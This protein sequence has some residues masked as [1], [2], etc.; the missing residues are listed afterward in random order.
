M[1]ESFGS[2]ES[3]DEHA[4][5]LGTFEQLSHDSIGFGRRVD[6][7]LDPPTGE[8]AAPLVESTGRQR[9]VG[10]LEEHSTSGD[11]RFGGQ[12]SSLVAHSISVLVV[13]RPD[14]ADGTSEAIETGRHPSETLAVDAEPFH[15]RSPMGQRPVSALRRASTSRAITDMRRSR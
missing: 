2:S 5:H 7:A 1:N 3:I 11:D 15:D 4:G 10:E 14:R 12:R 9:A 8:F 13:Q 6:V